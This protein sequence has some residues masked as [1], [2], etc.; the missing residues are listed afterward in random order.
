VLAPL[1]APQSDPGRIQT[2]LEV[3]IHQVLAPLSRAIA[4]PTGESE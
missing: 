4:S 3:E 2:L 1:L